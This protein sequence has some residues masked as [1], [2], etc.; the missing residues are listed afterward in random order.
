MKLITTK[1]FEVF[2]CIKVISK[3]FT[4]IKK[5]IF[6]MA[7]LL[8]IFLG[9]IGFSQNVVQGTVPVQTPL[10]GFGVDG[11]AYA[12]TP[13]STVG[14]WFF[15]NIDDPSTANPGGIFRKDPINNTLV[16]VYPLTYFL[17]DDLALKGATDNTIFTSTNKI[18]DNPN[19]YTWGPGNIPPK[20]EME[21]VGVHFTYGSSALGGNEDDLWCLFTAD[22]AV[23]NGDS[24]IDFEFLQSDIHR[25]GVEAGSGG[26][27]SAGPDG[28]R[29]IGDL[30]ITVEFNNG[31]SKPNVY[32]YRWAASLEYLPVAFPTGFIYASSNLFNTSVPFPI[33]DKDPVGDSWIYDINQWVEG[34]INLSGLFDLIQDPCVRLST[35]FIRTRT[36]GESGTSELKGFPLDMITLNLD[37]TPTAPTVADVNYCGPWSGTLNATGCDNG[38]IKW[39]D[40]AVGGTKVHEGTTYDPGT[41]SQ[42][43]SYWLS[44]TV[45]DCEGQRSKVTITINSPVITDAGPD[46]TVCASS[47]D[48]TL[49]GSVSGGATTG[50]WS[51]GTGSFSPD[52]NALDAVYTPSAEEIAAGTV[53]LTLTSADPAGPCD[54]T[55]DSMDITI[56]PAVVTDAGPDQT[57]CASSPDVT[58]AG[59]VSGGATTGS[60]SGGTG[61]FSPDAN[62]LDAVYTPSAEEIAAGTVSLTLT[63]ADP[64]GPCD[65]TSDSMDI[66]IDPAVVTNAGPDQTV[67]ASSPDVTLAGSVSGGA[68]TGTWS[69]GSG[70]YNPDATALDAVYTPSATEIA[71]GTVTLTLTSADPAG[72]CDATSDMITITIDPAVVTNAGPDQTVCASSPDVTLAGS[73]SGGATTGTWSGGSGT[74]NPDA[75]ALDA[76]YTPSATEIAAGTV[77]LTLTSA[78]PAGPCDATSDMVTITI[79]NSVSTDAGPDQTVC[80]SSPQVTLAGSVSGGATTGSWS[81]G[82]GSFSPDANA[83]DAVY[84]PSATEIAAGTVTL[85]LTSAD[86]AG[87]CDATSDS[88]DITIDPAVVTD[89]GP[90]QTVCASS[91]QVTLAGSVSGG[92]TTGSWSGGTGS[93]NPNANA[94]DAVYTPSAA[95]IAAGTV[96]LTLTS[97]D[98]SSPCDATSDSMDIT[99]H[100]LPIVSITPVGPFC[101]TDGA[102][103]LVGSPSSPGTGVFSGPGVSSTGLFNPAT[104]NVGGN[105]IRY[106][107]TDQYTCSAYTEIEIVVNICRTDEGCTL[108]YWKNH[109]DKWCT[110]YQTCTLYNSV[111]ANSTLAPTLTLIQALNLKGN[112]A[113]ENL[114]RQSV[115]ALLNICSDGVAYSSEFASIQSLKDYV[116]AAFTSGAVNVAGSHLDLLNNAGCPLGGRAT[117]ASTCTLK[118]ADN[119]SLGSSV[120]DSFS[121]YPVPFRES[122]NIQYDFDYSSPA[123]IQM[124]DTQGRLL[125]TYKEANAFKGKVTTINIDFRTRASQ[126]YIV[127]VTTDREVFTKKIISDK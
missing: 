1:N 66:T 36:S 46:Q 11:D 87:P 59:S 34:A 48:V 43:T 17:Q 93:F 42:T 126:V 4:A 88:M 74:Y 127:K 96:T 108:G 79:G 117:T 85:T 94:L 124:F 77:T 33:Y 18:N 111:F 56:D 70:T 51:G 53:S 19:T 82:T 80:S 76:V 121:A 99:I 69:G 32:V 104:A 98:S 115:A 106:T 3:S 64:A 31:G 39:Y 2:W 21:N 107:Y 125:R 50:S 63:S 75:T 65:A 86:P 83:L 60:W 6:L 97:A 26:F 28:G 5:N 95:E 120:I 73:V 15:A 90:D 84:T 101:T 27:S 105:T 113:G 9:N 16:P 89:A 55:S 109:T 14:D 23:T 62:A 122:L 20:D 47:P 61:S 123:T 78:D 44:C 72:P 110:D 103:Q 102:I 41:I 58:L 35:L 68:T 91:P 49:A 37:L 38:T 92:A 22:R 81:G 52:A 7:L 30:L 57:V 12:G 45:D 13:V 10:T 119:S 25:T 112:T 67:C 114:A 118:I 8:S 54:A 100:P 24:Y 116:N 71:A 29:T 40:A